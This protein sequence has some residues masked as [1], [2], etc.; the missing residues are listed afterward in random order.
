LHYKLVPELCYDTDATVLFGTDTFLMGYAR[1]AHP[2]DFFNVRFVVAGAERVKPETREIWMERFGLRILEGYGATEC[3]P[4]LAVNTPMHNK[5]GTVGRLM[6]DISWRIEPVEGITEGGRLFVKGP[7]V[8]LGYLRADTPGE[9]EPPPGGWYDTGDIVKIDEKGFV[10]IL[11]RA[12][13]FSK[14]AGEMISLTAVESKIQLAFPDGEHAVVAIPD[15][16]KGEQLV[17]VTNDPTIDRK[18]LID[19]MKRFGAMELLIPRNIIHVQE[20][21]VLGSGKTDYVGLNRL[22]RES[23]KS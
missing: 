14:I 21:P 5:S 15:P 8:M 11:G 19:G 1:N 23:V 16:K 4:V 17:L 7:N 3:S 6:D 22:A 13:R 9:I 10:T 20:L 18:K 2:Y 12:K